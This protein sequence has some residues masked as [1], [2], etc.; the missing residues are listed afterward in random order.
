MLIPE[1]R[2]FEWALVTGET[3]NRQKQEAVDS[4]C[5]TPPLRRPPRHQHTPVY[6]T[7]EIPLVSLSIN[8]FPRD[9]RRQHLF[10]T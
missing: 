2:Q 9:V 3:T 4:A 6:R 8:L 1:S 10:K 7:S 5:M